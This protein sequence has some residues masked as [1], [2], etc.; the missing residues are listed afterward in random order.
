M[1]VSA[2]PLTKVHGGFQDNKIIVTTKLTLPVWHNTTHASPY[3]PKHLTTI[4][5]TQDSLANLS[6]E[7]VHSKQ[8]PFT[9][10]A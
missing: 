6:Q 10:I 1:R 3:I 8:A 5:I 9:N 2:T 4:A 7:N